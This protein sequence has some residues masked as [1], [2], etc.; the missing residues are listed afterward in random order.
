MSKKTN[1][2]VSTGAEAHREG[3]ELLMRLT[4]TSS[5]DEALSVASGRSQGPAY[6][7]TSCATNL[8]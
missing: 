4:G 2:Q 7:M 3:Q 5:V 1:I 6:G 8:S